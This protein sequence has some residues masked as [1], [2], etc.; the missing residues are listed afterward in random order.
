[1]TSIGVRAMI[2]TADG[3]RHV[4][5][6]FQSRQ[7]SDLRDQ[8]SVAETRVRQGSVAH[9]QGSVAQGNRF[10]TAFTCPAER[11]T[12]KSNIHSH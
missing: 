11:L 3:L 4:S 6:V 8:S 2:T 5:G 12:Q 1:M 9:S 7:A 10:D